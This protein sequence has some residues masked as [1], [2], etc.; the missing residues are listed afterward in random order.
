MATASASP[1]AALQSL[2]Q[3]AWIDFISREFLESGG[4]RR[5]I[6]EDNLQG[7]T[8]NPT[9]FD[10]AI[11][12]SADYDDQFKEL[13]RAGKDADAIY[14]ALTSTDIGDALDLFRPTYDRTGGDHG[15]V[16]LEVSPTMAHST[17]ETIREAKKLWAAL[18]RP[19]AM[20]KIPGTEEG[21]S[22][23]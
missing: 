23:I 6:E 11:S 4:L 3:C 19:N 7:V 21:V 14:Y 17:S 22:A 18:G 9:I 15:F 8:S 13:V 20:I 5:L 16:S 12:H 1:I 2:G 10:K